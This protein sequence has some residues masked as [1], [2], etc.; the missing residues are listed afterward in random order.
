ML[1]LLFIPFKYLEE[2]DAHPAGMLVGVAG[3]QLV[4]LDH[5]HQLEVRQHLRHLGHDGLLAIRKGGLQGCSWY[6]IWLGQSSPHALLSL[7][8][9]Y[10]AFLTRRW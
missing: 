10:G 1:W 3:V 6:S 2:L 8:I 5:V 9:Q 4:G 7:F